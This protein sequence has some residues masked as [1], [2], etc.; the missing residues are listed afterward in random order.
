MTTIFSLERV[1]KKT[2]AATIPET[3]E[4]RLMALVRALL[5]ADACA[6]R[7]QDGAPDIIVCHQG[8]ALGL[9]LKAR[10]ESYTEAQAQVFPKLRDAGMRIETA[11]DEDQ[12]LNRLREMGVKL[13][14]ESRHAV[15]DSF[16]EETR[17]RT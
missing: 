3:A 2:S 7:G 9:E 4:E 5:P 17:R 13:K 11:R 8:R 12:A 1:K 16:R 15:R 6:M 14:E 10:T